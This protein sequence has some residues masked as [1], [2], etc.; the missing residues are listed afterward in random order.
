ML[1]HQYGAICRKVQKT[2]T[3][4]SRSS[5]GTYLRQDP[6]NF[7]LDPALEADKNK[8]VSQKVSVL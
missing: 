7:L 6:L 3:T 5:S 8:A 1:S 4:C 2:T